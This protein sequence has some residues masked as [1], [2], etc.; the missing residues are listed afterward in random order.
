[1]SS[2]LGLFPI[3]W[4]FGKSLFLLFQ[5]F[6]RS[7]CSNYS[8]QSNSDHFRRQPGNISFLMFVLK[9]VWTLNQVF[10][11]Q[12]F[13][14]FVQAIVKNYLKNNTLRTQSTSDFVKI[15]S[16]WAN[17]I[18]WIR[19]WPLWTCFIRHF[20]YLHFVRSNAVFFY[21]RRGHS[22]NQLFQKSK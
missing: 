19:F 21:I 10:Y 13:F 6:F 7:I 4:S 15:S 9:M 17:L 11:Y 18:F 5:H 8:P 1:M 22:T 20:W 2:C 12:K 14:N 16:V 3:W